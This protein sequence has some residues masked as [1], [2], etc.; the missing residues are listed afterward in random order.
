MIDIE[1]NIFYER[2]TGYIYQRKY[3]NG[4]VYY[5]PLKWVGKFELEKYLTFTKDL[6]VKNLTMQ[7]MLYWSKHNIFSYINV[8]YTLAKKKCE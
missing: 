5:V 8:I 3:Y 4:A 7:D 2:S 1:N 6:N